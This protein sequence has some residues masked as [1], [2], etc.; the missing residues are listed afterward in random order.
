MNTAMNYKF[1]NKTPPMQSLTPTKKSKTQPQSTVKMKKSK[2]KIKD[3]RGSP[4]F[5][6]GL[7]LADVL[8][9]VIQ[10]GLAAPSKILAISPKSRDESQ[11][12]ESPGSMK[13]QKRRARK[14]DLVR[15][16][17]KR[18]ER[19]VSCTRRTISIKKRKVVKMNQE[20]S[21][22][23][24]TGKNKENIHLKM[25]QFTMVSGSE[26]SAMAT[27]NSSGPMVH[28]TKAN[29]YTTRLTVEV[30][31][32]T[33]MVTFLTVSGIKTK[34]MVLEHISM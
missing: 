8:E 1:M 25:E 20:V 6:I 2:T 34:L 24:T 32:I 26:D 16:S 5:Q 13:I 18:K 9:L 28:D 7:R 12:E 4:L 21:K 14:I 19:T 17:K 27:V 30:S 22:A 29:G 23:P 11:T 15:K 3:Q 31:F 10:G 33:S